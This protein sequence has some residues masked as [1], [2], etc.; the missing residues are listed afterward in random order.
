MNTEQTTEQPIAL[1]AECQSKIDDAEQLPARYESLQITT[2]TDYETAGESLRAIKA[3]AKQ[4]SE[5]RLSLTRPLD[6]SKR[7]IMDLFRGPGAALTKA[8][9][10]IKKAMLAFTSEQGRVR[11]AEEERL[12]E[13]QRKEAAR[14]ANL[15]EKARARKDEAKAAEFEARQAN[16]ESTQVVVA[17]AA[18]PKAPGISTREIWEY[19]IVDATQIPADYLIPDHPLIGQTV[20]ATK[21]KVTIPG[22]RIFSRKTLAAG[23]R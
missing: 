13:E 1:D 18:I 9:G 5:L 21:G 3:K 10:F 16:V 19:E 15:A 12:R 20:R 14:L 22:V 6:E 8:E 17:P 7:K 23:S 11:R 2:A 4:L